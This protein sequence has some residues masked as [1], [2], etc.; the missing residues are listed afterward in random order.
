MVKAEALR[1]TYGYGQEREIPTEYRMLADLVV[2]YCTMP[3]ENGERKIVPR[4][5]LVVMGDEVVEIEGMI[6]V[7][8]YE[9][10]AITSVRFISYG[11]LTLEDVT[12]LIPQARLEFFKL[13]TGD[14]WATA[15]RVTGEILKSFRQ[16]AEVL[17][18][19]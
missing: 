1:T 2:D 18:E 16:A 11:K 3:I 5:E 10:P 7:G 6:E 9:R 14:D 8:W 15:T 19:E 17:Q 13:R 4:R 12:R